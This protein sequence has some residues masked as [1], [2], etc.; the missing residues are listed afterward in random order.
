LTDLISLV[1]TAA[2]R[3]AK[4]RHDLHA[5][6]VPGLGIPDHLVGSPELTRSLD[7]A[8]AALA[9]A[10]GAMLGGAS[11]QAGA[12]AAGARRALR[13]LWAMAAVL[14]QQNEDLRAQLKEA[15]GACGLCTACQ[16]LLTPE[17]SCPQC[18]GTGVRRPSCPQCAGSG[19]QA[20]GRTCP[21]CQGTTFWPVT[22]AEFV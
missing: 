3:V 7:E 4:V 15:E 12:P 9:E 8:E 10:R 1:Q 21:T 13:R 6:H 2:D 19:V 16:P 14:L 5:V 22:P 17:P 18:Y 11:D 20:Q